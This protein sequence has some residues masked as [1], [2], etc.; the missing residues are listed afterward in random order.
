MWAIQLV[1]SWKKELQKGARAQGMTK[2]RYGPGLGFVG[3]MGGGLLLP[4]V[5]VFNFRTEGVEFTDDLIF[6]PNKKGIFQLLILPNT[7]DEVEGLT[8]GLEKITDISGG[9]LLSEE[10]SIIIQS[11]KVS[12]SVRGT[13]NQQQLSRLASGDEFATS[14]LC[15]NRQPPVGYDELRLQKEVGG[16]K[17]IILRPDRFV[18][19]ACDTGRDLQKAVV[20]L[21]E[22]LHLH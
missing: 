19:A 15:K 10:A 3:E 1:P 12:S 4:Q 20:R 5:Y 8:R 22:A 16:K 18:Y 14:I 6:S 7:V 21:S 2:Y 9:L 17:Y 11:T 13:S